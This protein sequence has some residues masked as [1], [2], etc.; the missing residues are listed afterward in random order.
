MGIFEDE[1]IEVM[2]KFVIL[3]F[4]NVLFIKEEVK[5]FDKFMLKSDKVK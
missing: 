1:F 3:G 2:K 4:V 5:K